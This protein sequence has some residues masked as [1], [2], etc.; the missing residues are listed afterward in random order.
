MKSQGAIVNG[1]PDRYPIVIGIF[2]KLF[3]NLE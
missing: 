3:K 1:D 2:G